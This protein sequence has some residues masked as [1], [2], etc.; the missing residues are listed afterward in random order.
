[1]K[2]VLLP[3][4]IIDFKCASDVKKLLKEKSLQIG[5]NEPE[6]TRLEK[7]GYIVLDFGKEI[8]GAFRL[9]VH[10]SSGDQKLKITYGESVSEALS[11]VGEKGAT[12]DHIVRDYEYFIPSYSDTVFT[13]S[14]FRFV[15]LKSVGNSS[16][17][18]KSAVVNLTVYEK[19][20]KGKFVCD[21]KLV[22]KIFSTAAYTLK[23]CLQN[24]MIWDGIKRDRL[25]WIGDI[26]PE[27]LTVNSVY[28]SIPHV[29]NSLAF[30][31]EQSPLPMWM[32]NFPTYSL[33]WIVSLRDYYF[34]NKNI[35][36]L[37]NQKDYLKRLVTQ[38]SERVKENGE[39]DY[40]FIFIDW[41]TH[42]EDGDPDEDK[43]LDEITG[44]HALTV[45]AIKKAKELFGVLGEDTKECD[46]VLNRLLKTE[47][48]VKKYKQIS[49]LKLVAGIGDKSDADLIVNGGAKGMST[50]M[51]Y[52]ILKGAVDYGYQTESIEMLKDY[53]G[54]MLNL[55]ATSF[56]E[57]FDVAWAQNAGRIDRKPTKG[58]DDI[59]GDFGAFCYKGFR[60]SFCH[61]WASGVAPFLMNIVAGIE[62]V[63]AGCEEIR[64][65]PRLGSLTHVKVDYPTPYGILKVEHT[66][67]D[68]GSVETKVDAPNGVKIV[69]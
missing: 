1:M 66:R 68:D 53:Y 50:F 63:K 44:T 17:T 31:K 22:N 30:A 39:T 69:K 51:S 56:W 15:C 62:I 20:F 26:N 13:N 18:I 40:S 21:D 54:A 42:F 45:Y 27:I 67:R 33:W 34:Q 46:N 19:P 3:K 49:A 48:K 55:G 61:G 28:G 58:K 35:E 5:L 2:N 7:D 38:I 25:V 16:F 11:C 9:L 52:F 8:C 12:N 36:F 37:R 14:G 32:N 6:V 59:H 24:G 64:I 10:L 29:E 47:Y 65:N 57:D 23:L 43:R 60:H 41:P 4:K